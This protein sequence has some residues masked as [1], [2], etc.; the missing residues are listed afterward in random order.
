V[1]IRDVENDTEFAA[2]RPDAKKAG[3]RSV[4][5][6]PPTT[7]TVIVRRTRKWGRGQITPSST[8]Y[9]S[10]LQSPHAYWPHPGKKKLLGSQ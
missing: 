9:S 5:S 10:L 8:T 3:F 2:F 7:D 6:T 4:Q 1:I